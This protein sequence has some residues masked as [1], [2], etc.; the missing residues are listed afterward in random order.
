MSTSARIAA[1]VVALVTWIGLA[2][3]LQASTELA[4][5]V[6][7]A[8][9][10]MLRFF[11]VIAN[12]LV[13]IVFTIL[14]LSG[15]VAPS[16]LGCITLAILFVGVIYTLLLR[17]LIELSGGA[18]W[19]DLLLHHVTPVLVPLFW[20]VFARKGGLR[21]VDPWLWALLPLVYF[22]YAIAR[23]AL[24]GRYPYPFMDVATIGW[25]QTAINAAVMALGFV[26]GGYVFYGLD[27]WM[28]RRTVAATP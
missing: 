11:T 28:S 15:R 2:V 16:L 24:D 22:I 20:L 23:A 27:R 17:G 5:T 10:A 3:Q 12:L 25:A 26:V 6:P 14:A 7:S 13:A 21:S 9:W 8:I 18:R 4:G 1:I 19:A